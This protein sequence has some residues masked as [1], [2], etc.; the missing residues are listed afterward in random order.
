MVLIL[1]ILITLLQLTSPC[2]ALDLG[3]ESSYYQYRSQPSRDGIG[4]LYHGREIAKVMGHEG[5]LW[6]ERPSRVW[7]EHPQ[8]AIEA[9]DIKPTDVVADIGAGSGYM[10]FLIAPLVPQGKVLA[11]D[12]QPEMLDIIEYLKSERQIENVKTI[13]STTTNPN[14]P[15]ESVDLVL[16]VD[17]YHEFAYPQEMLTGIVQG[18]K[19]QGRVALV[20]YR[21]EN[22]F[23]AIKTLHKMSEK[24]IKTELTS[25][26][27]TWQETI[28]ILPQ[29]HIVIFGKS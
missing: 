16:M 7:Q 18:L 24:Q 2:L 19:P 27:L 4:K 28:E 8:A 11:V 21:R 9:L 1:A 10:T 17:A 26:G 22:P 12:I 15:P 20:E 5:V 23:I 6:L 14:L 29:Q 3:E 13:L 25:V